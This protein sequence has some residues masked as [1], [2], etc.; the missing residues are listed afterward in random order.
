MTVLPFLRPR[1]TLY[2]YIPSP[3]LAYIRGAGRGHQSAAAKPPLPN[4]WYQGSIFLHCCTSLPRTHK[5][6]IIPGYGKSC[7]IHKSKPRRACAVTAEAIVA[8]QPPQP[9]L[10]KAWEHMWKPCLRPPTTAH[11]T[12]RFM[13][14]W[15]SR[16]DAETSKKKAFCIA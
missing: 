14:H 5:A 2:I 13:R 8:N 4:N 6:K 3:L 12:R 1:L 11:D 10:R 7:T 9:G 16:A 15:N